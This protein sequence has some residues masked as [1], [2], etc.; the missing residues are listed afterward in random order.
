MSNGRLTWEIIKALAILAFCAWV[1]VMMNG[2]V[3]AVPYNECNDNADCEERAIRREDHEF[4]RKM[5][6]QEREAC[7]MPRTWDR[8]SR[9]CRT[10]DTLL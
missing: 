5:H 2:C 10:G 7:V 4:Y 6:Q 8:W 3:M 1:V 9:Q